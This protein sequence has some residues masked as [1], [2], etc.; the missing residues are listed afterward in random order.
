LIEVFDGRC[1]LGTAYG[2]NMARIAECREGGMSSCPV[3]RYST[4][5]LS[6]ING[7]LTAKVLANKHAIICLY[8]PPDSEFLSR[9]S[10][11]HIQRLLINMCKV[12]PQCPEQGK[13]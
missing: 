8:H 6:K 2:S 10:S 1:H 4:P 13:I 12:R 9:S 7:H 11:L 3:L 5:L